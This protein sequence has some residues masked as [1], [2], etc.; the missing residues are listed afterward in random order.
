MCKEWDSRLPKVTLIVIQQSL[1]LLLLLLAKLSTVTALHQAPLSP[2][3]STCF[4]GWLL[5]HWGPVTSCHGL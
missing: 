4:L 5:H 2:G 1:L 3:L